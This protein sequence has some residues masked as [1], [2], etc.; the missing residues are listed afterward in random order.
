MKKLL[1]MGMVAGLVLCG[2]VTAPATIIWGY[3][4]WTNDV[5]PA[6]GNIDEWGR[7]KLLEPTAFVPYYTNGEYA[8]NATITNGPGY[9]SIWYGTG[10]DAANLQTYKY[11]Y[12]DLWDVRGD[13]KIG[14]SGE[15]SAGYMEIQMQT[16]CFGT[17]GGDQGNGTVIY[18]PGAYVYDLSI[19]QPG[20]GG[21][22]TNTQFILVGEG[23]SELSTEGFMVRRVQFRDDNPF[24]QAVPEPAT[25]GMLGLAVAGL[26]VLRRR[27]SK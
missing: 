1:L 8:G 11:L 16:N 19:W 25:L 5:N 7:D 27:R 18:N 14:V 4:T 2:A 9:G 3:E 22:Y 15:S 6:D 17:S 21:A 12:I 26:T 10:V 23:N 13:V 20:V 24:A